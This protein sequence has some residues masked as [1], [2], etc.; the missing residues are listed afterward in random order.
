MLD[1]RRQFLEC[2]QVP[3]EDGAKMELCYDPE[4]MAILRNTD[5]LTEITEKVYFLLL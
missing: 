1:P 3:I 2:F 4:W 5:F